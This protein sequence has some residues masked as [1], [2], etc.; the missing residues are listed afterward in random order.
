MKLLSFGEVLW[1]VFPDKAVIGGA[2]LNFAAH[3]ARLGGESYMLSA[4]GRDALGEN[5]LECLKKWGINTKYVALSDYP[6]GSCQVTLSENGIPS[7]NLLENVAYDYIGCEIEDNFDLLYFGTLAVNGEGNRAS[8]KKVIE[9]NAFKDIFCDINIRPPFFSREN[10]EFA[11][12]NATVLK[13]SDEEL[14][15][16]LEELKVSATDYKSAVLTLAKQYKNLKIIII[17]LGEKGSFVYDVLNG[18]AHSTD[19]E[20]VEVVS[21][22]GAGDSFS[23]AFLYKYTVNASVPDC[24]AAATRLSAFVVSQLGAIPDY[25]PAFI[26]K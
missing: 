18:E 5:A 19:S 21:T 10:I 6:T 11:L 14:P 2:P 17:T 4:V 20:K 12:N 13:I 23:A 3:F 1:D 7:Y 15:V 8:L 16:I 25:D 24:L 22:V 9:E 26:L